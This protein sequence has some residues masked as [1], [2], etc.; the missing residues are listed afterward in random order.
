MVYNL[1]CFGYFVNKTVRDGRLVGGLPMGAEQKIARSK[2]IASSSL[3][4]NRIRDFPSLTEIKNAPMGKGAVEALVAAGAD[5]K[6]LEKAVQLVI[7]VHLSQA[8]HRIHDVGGFTRKSL[9]L[10]PEEL[11]RTARRIELIRGNSFYNMALGLSGSLTRW[12]ETCAN[13]RYLAA[14]LHMF[15]RVTR[16]TAKRDPRRYDFRLL[17]KRSLIDQVVKSTGRPY[18]NRL[19]ELLNAAYYAADLPLNEEASALRHLWEKQVKK[20]RYRRWAELMN[21]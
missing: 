20:R 2:G 19:A 13:L 5:P 14:F 18:F 8:F 1:K 17:A 11:L 6:K 3:R 4:S 21:S 10:F 9:A 16:E 7:A 15:I 12:Q